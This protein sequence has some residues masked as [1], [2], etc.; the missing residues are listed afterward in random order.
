MR[1]HRSLHRDGFT[2]VEALVALG[3]FAVGMAALMPL[4]IS[5]VRANSNAA[6]RTEALA[7]AQE[8]IE[9]FRATTFSDMPAVG[10]SG[11]PTVIDGVF[12][13]QWNVSAVPA[14]LTGDG[15][16][17]RRVRVV[18]SWNLADSTGSVTLTTAKTRY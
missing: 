12:T 15:D 17:L 3:I 10:A 8:E 14:P 18:V 4:A 1:R 9:R 16:D 13:R 7:L 11:T 5:N 2:L 6:V